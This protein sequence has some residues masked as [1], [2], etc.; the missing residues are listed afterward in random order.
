MGQVSIAAKVFGAV[1]LLVGIGV[2]AIRFQHA[3][4]YTIP[5]WGP[6]LGA[7]GCLVLG[8]LFYFPGKPKWFG[9]LMIIVS[10]IAMF[11]ALYSIGGETEEVISVYAFDPN[12]TEVDL[13]LWIVDRDDGAWVGLGKSKAVDNSMDGAEL[14]MLR[15][16]QLSCVK[17]KLYEDRP[18]VETI[19]AMKVDKYAVAQLSAAIG[20]YPLE[21]PASA[22]AM[23]L[24][25]C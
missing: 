20:L 6:M 11:P 21:A 1:L 12:G 4:P 24:D 3:G 25:P 5:T 10:P 18:T 23:R 15:G 16:G 22:V 8:G 9:Y 14:Q 19:H 13:R 7:L 2:F 17:P